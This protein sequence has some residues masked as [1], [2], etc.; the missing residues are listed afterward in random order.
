MTT[1]M[2][3]T[4]DRIKD[5]P[6]KA[7]ADARKQALVL[8]GVADLAVAQAKEVP[9]EL[10]AKAR[11]VQTSVSSRASSV[12]STVKGLPTL[13]RKLPETLSSLGSS[14]SGRASSAQAKASSTYDTLATR[15]EKLV[16]SI[17]RQK[18]T[19]VAV[20]EGRTAVKKAEAATRNA[21]RSAAATASAVVDAADKIG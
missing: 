20:T 14:V 17:R 21:K 8:V 11:Q 16:T 15:G 7:F 5:L 12:P 6:T 1:L 2:T 4:T 13:P 18:A 19:E 10:S 3:S 9:A